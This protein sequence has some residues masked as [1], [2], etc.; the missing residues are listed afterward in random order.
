MRARNTYVHRNVPVTP[1]VIRLVTGKLLERKLI[2][3]SYRPAGA[4]SCARFVNRELISSDGK[5][6]G[7]AGCHRCVK[8]EQG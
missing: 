3:D 4:T 1:V 6:R 8:L 5:G 7:E 2:K